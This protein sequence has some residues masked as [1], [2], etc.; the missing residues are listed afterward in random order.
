MVNHPLFH[1]IRF[2]KVDLSKTYQKLTH[3][4]LR[5]RF[6]GSSGPRKKKLFWAKLERLVGK[7]RFQT[8]FWGWGT[9]SPD[10]RILFTEGSIFG[11]GGERFF[12]VGFFIGADFMGE[13][14]GKTFFGII[15]GKFMSRN[16]RSVGLGRFH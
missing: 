13:G 2:F 9:L 1:V 3:F 11:K 6:S 12:S 15:F 8:S 7:K 14:G 10:F 16:S 5:G 4:D